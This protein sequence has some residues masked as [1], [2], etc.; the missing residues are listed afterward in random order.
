[1]SPQR[2][3]QNGSPRDPF[4]IQDFTEFMDSVV[5]ESKQFIDAQKDYYT[6]VAAEKAAKGAGSALNSVVALVLLGSVLV[7]FNIALALW[8]GEL[9]SSFPLG[10]LIVGSGYLVIYLIFFLIWKNGFKHR[11]TL[12]IINAF[13]N[14]KD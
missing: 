5:G 9:L 2:T 14:E 1:M 10:F 8:I 3:Q 13:Y 7:F 4:E 6:L 11:F 12:G